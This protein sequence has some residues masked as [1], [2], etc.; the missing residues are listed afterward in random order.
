MLQVGRLPW[1]RTLGD[2]A[3]V[4]VFSHTHLQELEAELGGLFVGGSEGVS[5]LAEVDR[6]NLQPELI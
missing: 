3:G 6:I 4:D 2:T 1:W 5:K